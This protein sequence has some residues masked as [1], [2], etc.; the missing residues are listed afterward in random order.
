MWFLACPIDPISE[1]SSNINVLRGLKH[2]AQDSTGALVKQ[3]S[4]NIKQS[5]L[6][7]MSLSWI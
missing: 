4:I 7:I 5:E 6:C 3:L 1:H 2:P